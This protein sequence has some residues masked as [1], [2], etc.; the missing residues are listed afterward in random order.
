MPQ[1][2]KLKLLPPSRLHQIWWQRFARNLIPEFWTRF[3]RESFHGV[4]FVQEL[5]F[6]I[7]LEVNLLGLQ[8]IQPTTFLKST[9]EFAWQGLTTSDKFGIRTKDY[10][11][12]KVGGG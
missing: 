5:P 3:F 10:C 6:R 12:A 7:G 4:V 11:P 8:V 1:I 9:L 2:H